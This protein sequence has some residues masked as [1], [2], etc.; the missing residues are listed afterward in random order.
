MTWK[1]KAR[2]SSELTV[3]PKIDSKVVFTMFMNE[4]KRAKYSE[5]SLLS[6]IW[7]PP[8]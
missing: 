7:R 2:N 1:L 4:T 8:L 3:Y 5:S 6:V